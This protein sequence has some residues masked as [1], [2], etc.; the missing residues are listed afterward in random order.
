MSRILIGLMSLLLA[1][2]VVGCDREN[3]VAQTPAGDQTGQ[4]AESA[5]EQADKTADDASAKMGEAVDAAKTAASKSGEAVKA[6]ASEAAASAGETASEASSRAGQAVS[7][8]AADLKEGAANVADS[9]KQAADKAGDK[10]GAAV[11]QVGESAREAA[12]KAEETMS[13]A[14]EKAK[15]WV[16]GQS[17]SDAAATSSAGLTMA[18]LAHQKFTLAKVNGADYKGEQTPFIMF[19]EDSIVSGRICNNFRGPGKLDGS[20]LT[21]EPIAS[22]R[23]LCD[24]EGLSELENRFFDM[25]SQG[26][27]ISMDGSRLIFK[28]GGSVLVFEADSAATV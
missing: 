11:D 20:V 1:I 27:E 22:T 26:A 28:Q 15:E 25:L 13:K 4:A 7:D 19:D 24:F 3:G 17:S 21:V 5:D 23:M 8:I 2:A 16:G 18:F 6:A 10:L 12:G 14:A 9:A